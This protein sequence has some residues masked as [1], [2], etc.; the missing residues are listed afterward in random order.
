MKLT[1]PRRLERLST[2]V[3]VYKAEA[4]PPARATECEK[5]AAPSPG[6]AEGRC[7]DTQGWSGAGSIGEGPG[8]PVI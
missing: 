2:A 1:V 5:G 7:G 3:G 6:R 4:A 8:C